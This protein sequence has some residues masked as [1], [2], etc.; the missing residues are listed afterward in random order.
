M[1]ELTNEAARGLLDRMHRGDE[2]ALRE[3]QVHLGRRIYAFALNRLHD[4]GEAEEVVTDTL[5]EVW[6]HHGR[7]SGTSKFSTWV[8]GIARN[9]ILTAL[10][11]RAPISDELDE[12]LPDEGLGPFEQWQRHS[13]GQTVQRCI[14]KLSDVHR[15]CLQLVFF[16]ELSVADVAQLQGCPQNTVKTRLFHARLN[17]KKC[18]E[19]LWAGA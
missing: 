15:E 6:K 13:E 19:A 14:E 12:E 16:Q 17:L 10:R 18:L 8:L 4:E 11:D 5:W 2:S 3:L 7:F 9:K 1:K